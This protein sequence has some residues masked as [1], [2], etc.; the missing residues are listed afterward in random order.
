MNKP[1]VLLFLVIGLLITGCTNL[2]GNV[3]K[4]IVTGEKTAAFD[5]KDDIQIFLHAI[6]H[7]K[8][9]DGVLDVRKSNYKFKIIYKN[10]K[11]KSYSL[12]LGDH[13]NGMIMD[14]ENTQTGY[15]LA[16]FDAEKLLKLLSK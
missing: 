16:K 9:I 8:K 13:H 3:K 2:S 11:T 7:S 12:W 10:K 5:G 6:Q 14:N 1:V 4:V 15:T